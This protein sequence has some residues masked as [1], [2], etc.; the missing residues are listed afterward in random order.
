MP[1]SM[2]QEPGFVGRRLTTA[3]GPDLF[4][5][6]LLTSFDCANRHPVVAAPQPVPT[7]S[8]VAQPRIAVDVGRA[9][10]AAA[11]QCSRLH[12][13]FIKDGDKLLVSWYHPILTHESQVMCCLSEPKIFDLLR[14]QAVLKLVFGG[15]ALAA[16]I[17]WISP[18]S[19]LLPCTFPAPKAV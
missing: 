11:C 3:P 8:A 19:S 6:R 14:D 12:A 1:R 16:L 13:T 15:L 18:W 4:R 5:Q 7:N 2:C 17:G 10:G 9:R